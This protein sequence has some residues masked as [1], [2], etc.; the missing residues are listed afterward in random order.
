MNVLRKFGLALLAPAIALVIAM[1]ISSLAL[2]ASG[3][4]PGTTYSNMWEYGT[5]YRSLITR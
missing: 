3:N 5:R 4:S 1:V 2:L